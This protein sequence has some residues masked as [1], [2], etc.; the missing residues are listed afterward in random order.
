VTR[1]V[2]GEEL[3]IQS[4]DALLGTAEIEGTLF[5]ARA[6]PLVRSTGHGLQ[7][8]GFESAELERGLAFEV[9]QTFLTVLSA[10]RLR[11]AAARRIG[12]AEATVNDARVRLDAGL[13]AVNDVSR[14]DLERASARLSLT[15][16]ESA[17][18]NSR[19][20]LAYLIDVPVEAR[21]LAEPAIA[22]PEGRD[23]AA[24]EES[25]RGARQ[26][27]RALEQRAEAALLRTRE[28]R[29]R[30]VPTLDLRGT[31]R[32]TNETGL[33]GRETDWNVAALLTWELFDGGVSRAEAAVRDAEYRE[34]ELTAAALS[35]RIGLEVRTALADRETA[36]AA[37]EQSEAQAEVARQ[38]AV[39]VRERFAN[40][41]ATALERAD[42]AVAEFEAEAELAGQRFALE[43]AEL[44]LVQT[45][46][47][48]PG[49]E[50]PAGT[51]GVER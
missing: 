21:P 47:L 35:R 7:A 14:S 31:A 45:L 8:Q 20:A 11:A 4:R 42:A 51:T 44:T 43:L 36:R 6:I 2:N 1:E 46:G 15:Q 30:V 3:V 9:A 48:W 37:L 12:V 22:A 29:L 40:G 19:L 16:A 32:S 27:L 25:A 18:R 5:D 23:A 13:A 41:L 28:P 34:A 26:D 10:E 33:S 38:N 49:G 50:P 39:E 17:V 24:L